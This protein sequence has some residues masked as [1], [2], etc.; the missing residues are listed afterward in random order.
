MKSNPCFNSLV[1]RLDDL[2][3]YIYIS[4]LLVITTYPLEPSLLRNKNWFRV[5]GTIHVWKVNY[6]E[7]KGFSF[8][9]EV[10]GKF[11]ARYGNI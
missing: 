4:K 2:R 5:Y 6:P 3:I 11:K 9:V 7:I 8:I 1:V 10:G